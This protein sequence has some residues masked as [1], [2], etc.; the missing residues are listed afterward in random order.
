MRMLLVSSQMSVDLASAAPGQ[1]PGAN[2]QGPPESR[3]D[4]S[5]GQTNS[6]DTANLMYNKTLALIK[7]KYLTNALT[8]EEQSALSVVSDNLSKEYKD[9]ASSVLG[10]PAGGIEINQLAKLK[11]ISAIQMQMIREE[12][13]KLQKHYM[14]EVI[15]ILKL[16][17]VDYSVSRED[18]CAVVSCEQPA[19]NTFKVQLPFVIK[20]DPEFAS[21]SDLGGLIRGT[22]SASMADSLASPTI[23]CNGIVAAGIS[24]RSLRASDLSAW[25]T[26]DLFFCIDVFGRTRFPA[27]VRDEIWNLLFSKTVG[28]VG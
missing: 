26:R 2:V 6:P 11:N 13:K 8:K 20:Y 9:K 4:T 17:H 15:K 3:A 23:T 21:G 28:M 5:P 16:S 18:F 22:S 24:G 19:S 10:I 25:T 1:T 14:F 7:D 27:E 12:G